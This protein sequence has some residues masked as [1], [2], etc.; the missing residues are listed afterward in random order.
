MTANELPRS[1]L[2]GIQKARNEASFG[3]YYPKRLKNDMTTNRKRIGMR[4]LAA[5]RC[6]CSGS[7]RS[8]VAIIAKGLCFGYDRQFYPPPSSRGGRR[9]AIVQPEPPIVCA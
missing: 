5:L 1:K 4:L 2:R 6:Q 7:V 8:V 3:E 9:C